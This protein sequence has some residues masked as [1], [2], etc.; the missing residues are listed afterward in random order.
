MRLPFQKRFTIETTLSLDEATT[1][2]GEAIGRARTSL[3]E[4]TPQP[5]MGRLREDSFDIMRTTQ[6]RNSVRPRIRGKVEGRV[7]GTT[8]H[9][10]MKLHELVI[11]VLAFIVLG[12]GLIFGNIWLGG[13]LQGHFD[14]FVL[15]FPAVALFLLLLFALG[16]NSES[17]RALRMLA[18]IV[19]ADRSRFE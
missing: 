12:P 6:G 19:D 14:P 11:G 10:T 8:L 2:L 1:R 18:E 16:F 3:F 4:R 7:H 9:G 5:F 15:V 13:L 17:N